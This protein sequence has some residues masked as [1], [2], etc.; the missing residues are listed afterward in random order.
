MQLPIVIQ[1]ELTTFLYDALP[2]CIILA[3]FSIQDWF[4]G[5]YLNIISDVWK[6]G[7][8]YQSIRMRYLEGGMYFEPHKNR[9]VLEYHPIRVE[10]IINDI[11][12][13][14]FFKE[15]LESGFYSIAFF[16]EYF[17]SCKMSY[18]K[19][20]F[21]HESMIYGYDDSEGGFYVVLLD[22]VRNFTSAF[23]PY[24]EAVDGIKE[25]YSQTS[26]GLYRAYLHLLKPRPAQVSFDY[27]NVQLQIN[28]YL[29]STTALVDTYHLSLY[30]HMSYDWAA[31]YKFGIGV[32]D[33]LATA[34]SAID[35]SWALSWETYM[36]FHLL[37]EH[38]RHILKS[39][40]HVNTAVLEKPVLSTLLESYSRIVN[41]HELL[42]MRQLKFFS[43]MSKYPPA[44]P[45]SFDDTIAKL[46][47]LKD[48]ELAVLT[49]I[50]SLLP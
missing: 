26:E 18:K 39:L 28:N 3:H 35:P 29:K 11:G 5:H 16:D 10:P 49:Q 27:S 22:K 44:V 13:V 33:E 9:E 43:K 24:S 37:A 15:S 25:A 8:V 41:E 48:R 34:Y 20:H 42:R 23:I 30:D 45:P 6:C 47:E 7:A 38:K 40:C 4:L 19:N 12:L 21:V 14:N 1:K 46:R 32:Y 17:L 31:S 50:M 2:L 36:N